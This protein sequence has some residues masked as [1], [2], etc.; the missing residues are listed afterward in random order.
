MTTEI[1]QGERVLLNFRPLKL[2]N[3]L[4]FS[5]QYHNNYGRAYTTEDL[6]N[7]FKDP[8][9]VDVTI[10]TNP[11]GMKVI[12]PVLEKKRTYKKKSKKAVKQNIVTPEDDLNLQAHDDFDLTTRDE[13]EVVS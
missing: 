2:K 4:P 10:E 9:V 1:K 3:N 7:A 6:V 13:Q 5:Q 11:S 8:S 12:T